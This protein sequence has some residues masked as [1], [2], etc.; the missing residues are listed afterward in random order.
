M[1]R[2][3][4]A[5]TVVNLELTEICN[6]TCRHCYNFWREDGPGALSFDRETF[7]RLIDELSS[8]GVFHVVLTGGEPF[9]KFELLEYAVERLAKA[10]MTMSC[11]S[12]LTLAKPDNCKRLADKGLDHILTSLPSPDPETNDYLMRGKGTFER[13]MRGIEAAVG[14]G[15]RVSLNM[16]L[17]KQTIDQVYITGRIAKEKG[18][19]KL[20]VTRAVPPTYQH[21]RMPD[22]LYPTPA[23]TRRALEDALRVK[24]DFGV[25]IGTLVSYPLCFLGDLE[26]FRDFVGRGCPGQS[27]AFM[28]VY[29]NGDTHACVHEAKGYGNIL[30]RPIT[31]VFQ[32][33]ELRKWHTGGHHYSGCEGCP[34]LDICDT[35]CRMNAWAHNGSLDGR[36]PLFVGPHVFKRHFEVVTDTEAE[37][38]I[39]NDE[40]LVA[41]ARLR[42]RAEDGFHLLNIR[43]GNTIQVADDVAE[44]LIARRDSGAAFTL[45][46]F[47]RERADELIGLYFKDAVEMPGHPVSDQRDKAGLGWD[48]QALRKAAR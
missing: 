23:E 30:E 13:I 43:W 3:I 31:E 34:Y 44:F 25:M 16:V 35:G 24:A 4:S 21:G 2:P 45:S 8:A 5:P 27:G 10:G 12:N 14:A 26:K 47:G 40:P 22:D 19:Q 11:N 48:P 18:C 28:S 33:R 9:S 7:D 37:R 39:R 38:K 41:P 15:I 1:N 42:F 46:E 29:V 20:F 6:L 17:T 36:D 32:S